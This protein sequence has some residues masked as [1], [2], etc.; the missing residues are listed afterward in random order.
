MLRFLL[1]GF[2]GTIWEVFQSTGMFPS[3]PWGTCERAGDSAAS[4]KKTK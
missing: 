2:M 3:R 1:G 4:A